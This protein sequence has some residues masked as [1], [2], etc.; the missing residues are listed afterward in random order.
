MSDDE[1]GDEQSKGIDP[2]NTRKDKSG[3]LCKNAA[4]LPRVQFT[5]ALPKLDSIGAAYQA[6][7]GSS[8]ASVFADMARQS[9]RF[10]QIV[11]PIGLRSINLCKD[12]ASI[13]AQQSVFDSLKINAFSRMAVD[14][15]RQLEIL[16]SQSLRIN[17]HFAMTQQINLNFLKS[18]ERSYALGTIPA[19]NLPR[20]GESFATLDIGK[21]GRIIDSEIA[22]RGLGLDADFGSRF[23]NLA[24]DLT[25]QMQ[26]LGQ[27]NGAAGAAKINFDRYSSLEQMLGRAIAAQ[28]A[29]AEK[30][31]TPIDEAAHI[32]RDRQLQF[33]SNIVTILTFLLMIALQVEDRLRD[34]KDAAIRANTEAMEQMKFSIDA[35]KSQLRD[36]TASQVATTEQDKETDAA[37]IKLLTEIADSLTDRTDT[38]GPDGESETPLGDQ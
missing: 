10:K 29:L 34:D 8:A 14:L 23:I 9:E 31:Q 17:R 26:A 21:Y 20:I 32:N 35:L 28:A 1:G 16:K 15:E 4:A 12:L 30:D 22:R 24:K 27:Y 37:I 6:I 19:L 2:L 38:I 18:I 33:L 25:E 11:D 13:A 3:E 7:L 36:V 5:N